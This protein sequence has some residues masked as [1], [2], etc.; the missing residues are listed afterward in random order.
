MWAF[1][2]PVEYLVML[3]IM[4]MSVIV[5]VVVMMLVSVDVATLRRVGIN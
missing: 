5:L 1:I 4:V 3:S 2:I